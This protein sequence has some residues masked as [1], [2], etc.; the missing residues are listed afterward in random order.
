MISPKFY[1]MDVL[2]EPIM[3]VDVLGC[4]RQLCPP[5]RCSVVPQDLQGSR[6]ERHCRDAFRSDVFLSQLVPEEAVQVL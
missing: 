1:L 5:R 2:K 6:V 3:L 4:A